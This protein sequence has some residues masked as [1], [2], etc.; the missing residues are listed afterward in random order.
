MHY[1]WLQIEA[2]GELA[3]VKQRGIDWAH[4]HLDWI[5]NNWTR[6]ER[7]VRKQGMLFWKLRFE[8]AEL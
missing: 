7:R 6:K 1:L 2:G 3:Q 5:Q 8:N 4:L